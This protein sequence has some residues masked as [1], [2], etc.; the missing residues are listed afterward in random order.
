MIAAML[1][2]L[3]YTRAHS[4]H[5]YMSCFFVTIKPPHTS[6]LWHHGFRRLAGLTV[7]HV[8]VEW[9]EGWGSTVSTVSITRKDRQHDMSQMSHSLRLLAAPDLM[10]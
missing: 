2:L 10:D 1:Y 7:V 5:A 9:N 8:I 3:D 4:C 6:A